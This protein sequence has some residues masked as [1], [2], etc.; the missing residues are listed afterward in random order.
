[1]QENRRGRFRSR[2]GGGD[3]EAANE[4]NFMLKAGQ[5]AEI[6]FLLDQEPR[7]V[8][9]NTYLAANIP[10]SQRLETGTIITDQKRVPFYE[11]MR[12]LAKPVKYAESFETIVDNEDPGFE[13][14]NTGESRT[15]KDWWISRQNEE[16]EAD[17]YG[18]I[19]FWNPP[20]KWKPVAGGQ[21]FGEYLKSAYYKRRGTGNG[22]VIWNASLKESGHYDVYAHVPATDFGWRRHRENNNGE[23]DYLFTV[24]HDDGD[25]EVSITISNTNSGWIYLGE[26]YCSQGAAKVQLSDQTNGDLV[27]G[28]AVKWIKK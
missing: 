26:Y 25:D 6:G 12:D 16:T 11:G 9:V 15:L 4:Q 28:D 8:L 24:S 13:F 7:E 14:I 2:F 22:K 3:E 21:F 18:M 20:V 27:I 1:M 19:R 23:Q 10:S 5:S 17:E